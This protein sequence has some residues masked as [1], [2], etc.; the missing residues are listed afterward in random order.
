MS[1]PMPANGLPQAKPSGTGPWPGTCPAPKGCAGDDALFKEAGAT[2][3]ECC[4]YLPTDPLSRFLAH[5]V[6]QGQIPGADLAS[7]CWPKSTCPASCPAAL[8]GVFSQ[9]G[10]WK[11]LKFGSMPVPGGLCTRQSLPA[12]F[13]P[14]SR[15]AV[16]SSFW[17][18][19]PSGGHRLAPRLLFPSETRDPGFCGP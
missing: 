10:T 6:P 12:R 1:N 4:D 2:E 5:N 19:R 7:L 16:E 8:P 14:T 18:L 11:S 15:W 17:P 9:A 13:V 3:R